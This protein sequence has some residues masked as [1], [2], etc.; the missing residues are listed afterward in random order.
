MN[1]S[2]ILAPAAMLSGEPSRSLP[3]HVDIAALG[4]LRA[5]F[6]DTRTSR[7]TQRG[8]KVH[9]TTQTRKIK[10]NADIFFTYGLKECGMDFLK[11]NQCGL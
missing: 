10:E 11:D 1:T 9:L 2:A 5:C 4:K 7:Q 6:G 8:R 3:F